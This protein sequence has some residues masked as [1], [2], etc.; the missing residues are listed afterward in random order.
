MQPQGGYS[1]GRLLDERHRCAGTARPE[2][3]FMNTCTGDTNKHRYVIATLSQPL[4]SKLRAIP[5]VPI[6][7]VNRSVMILEPPSEISLRVKALVRRF[8]HV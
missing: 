3:S 6:L 5:G 8:L 1:R 2:T 7:H 4:R